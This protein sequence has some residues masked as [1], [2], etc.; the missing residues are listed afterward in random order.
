MKDAIHQLKLAATQN[1]QEYANIVKEKRCFTRMLQDSCWGGR[2]E[3]TSVEA[4]ISAWALK[5]G[6]LELKV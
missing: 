3:T 1:L 2:E 6:S 4:R 5:E